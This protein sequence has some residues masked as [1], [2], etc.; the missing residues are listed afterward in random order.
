M[1]IDTVGNFVTYEISA[2]P[3]ISRNQ[4]AIALIMRTYPILILVI[5]TSMKVM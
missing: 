4:L 5:L 3:T 1:P 2:I